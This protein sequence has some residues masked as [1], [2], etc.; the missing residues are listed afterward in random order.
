MA[1]RLGWKG[2]GHPWAG[3][4]ACLEAASSNFGG[5]G[6]FGSECATPGPS[7]IIIPRVVKGFSDSLSSSALGKHS[8]NTQPGVLS[9]C[10]FVGGLQDF[11][12]R[13]YFPPLMLEQEGKLLISYSSI[14]LMLP[15]NCCAA[16]LKGIL[17]FCGCRVRISTLRNQESNN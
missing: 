17:P 8:G 10:N 4:A 5:M 14:N 3:P 6:M 16:A 12:L 15:P 1:V 11:V 13:D 2:F 9:F 7:Q